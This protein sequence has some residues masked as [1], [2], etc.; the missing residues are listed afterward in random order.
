MKRCISSLSCNLVLAFILTFVGDVV[1]DSPKHGGVLEFV[2]G[3]KVTSYDGHSETTFGM[4]HPIRPFYSVLIRVDPDNPQSTT[5]FVCDL[6]IG[7]IPEPEDDGKR[8]TFKIRQGV[9]F[10]DGTPLTSADLKASFEKIIFPP[11]GIRSARKGRFSMVHSIEASSPTTL[12]FNLK[13]ASGAFLPT[14]ATPFN[15]IY[16]K[17]DLDTHGYRWHQRNVN[18]TGPFEFAQHQAGA[19][20]EGRRNPDYYHAGRPYLD[21]FRAIS[22]PKMSTRL[23]AIRGGRAAIEFRGFPPEARDDLLG[24]LGEKI[25]VQQSDWNCA[26]LVTPNHRVKPFDDPRVRRALTLALDRRLGATHLSRIAIVK[27]VGG[28]VYPHHPLAAS[29]SELATMA[30]YGDDIEKS[31]SLA[32]QL[33]IDAGHSGL[34]FTLHN[35]AVDQ[36]YKVVGTWLIDQWSRIGVAAEQQAKPSGPFFQSLFKKKDFE[37]TIEFSCGSVVNPLSDVGKYT[38]ERNFGEYED[39]VL[40]DLFERL[41]RATVPREQQA[42]MRQFERRVLDDAAHSFVTLWWHRIAL[43]HAYVKGWKISPSHYLNQALDNVWLDR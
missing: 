31:R 26:L 19:F 7:G 42:L 29:S 16:S 41:Q 2:V 11:P 17:K 20:L 33:L 24:A 5:R 27:T 37:V 9:K 15:F 23:Q 4:L 40:D 35:R 18:G 38:S 6:C 8:Y 12:T 10:H 39:P 28:I 34:T 30:G 32:R 22:A 43:H 3:S 25:T 13:H 1:A 36:P 21:G 14:L